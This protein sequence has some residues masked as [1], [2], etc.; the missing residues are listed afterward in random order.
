MAKTDART[1]GEAMVGADV[2]L[3]VSQ[4]GVLKP[5]MVASMAAKPLI[6]ALA[7]PTPEIMPAEVHAVRD[8]AIVATGR[9][10]FPNQ[11]NNVLCFPYLFRGA[12][13]VGATSINEEMKMAACYA[14]ADLAKSPAGEEV[15]AA[16]G[17]QRLAYGPEYVIP[18]PFDPRLITV[19][20]VAVAKAAMDSGV[21]R[22]PIEDLAAYRE[23]LDG[24]M[25]RQGFVMKPIIDRARANPLKVA[26]AEG[27]DTRVLRAVIA[28]LQEGI[29]KPILIGRRK[30]IAE[31][32]AEHNMPIDLDRDVEVIEPM[33]NPYYKDCWEGYHAL[34][35]REGVDPQEAR[36]HMNTRPTVLAAM[37]V[38]L[39]YADTMVCGALGRY[40]R[41]LRRIRGIFGTM[42]RVKDLSAMTM[43]LTPKGTF[44]ITDTHVQQAPDAEALADIALLAA[45]TV[46]RLGITPKVALVSHSNFGSRATMQ[47]SKVMREALP[48]IRERAPDLMVEGEMHA[49]AALAEEVRSITMPEN[50]LEGSAN[51]LVMPNIDAANISYNLLK[52][53]SDG[54]VVGPMLMGI[55]RPLALMTNV[56][57][58]RRIFNMT[59]IA[60]TETQAYY[61]RQA[62]SRQE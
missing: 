19:I 48:I 7:N 56:A 15:I 42:D 44:F 41:H 2:F 53:L 38:K 46:E 59:A 57:T 47:S 1:L 9:S 20:P 62:E 14:I 49:D 24:M 45:S 30:R 60:V 21:A 6:L 51:I 23:K 34:R 37:L 31:R 18:K 35:G 50:R 54:N 10:D 27:E 17:G 12:L 13:D 43:I 5:E 58:A 28:C 16:Y 52:V 22:R 36:I 61:A 39:G 3:G 8:D 33:N 29:C 26:F 4:A 32:I 40:D 11:V 25:N 55:R